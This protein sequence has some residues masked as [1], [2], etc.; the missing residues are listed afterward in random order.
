MRS[1]MLVY[2][3]I[4]MRAKLAGGSGKFRLR[5]EARAMEI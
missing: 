3:G 2:R 1:A 4:A 5:M